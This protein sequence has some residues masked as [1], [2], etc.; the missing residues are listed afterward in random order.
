MF[1][2]IWQYDVRPGR[3]AEFAA[4]YGDG[5]AWAALF[6]EHDGHLGTQLLRDEDAAE[7]FLTIDR[8]TSQAA[9]E[10]FLTS[11]Q[12]RYAQI[13]ALGDALT[14]AERCIGRY[15]SP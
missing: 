1:V 5:G 12:P 13:D 4:L 14:L 8:W 9:Y 15:A 2:V 6:R 7:R 11:A 10:R 3:E